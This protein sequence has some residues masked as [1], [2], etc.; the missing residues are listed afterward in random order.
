MKKEFEYN[1]E[2]FNKCLVGDIEFVVEPS[3]TWSDDSWY[4]DQENR[5]LF[6]ND[7]Y[8]I[9]QE[10]EATGTILGG[11]LCTFNLLQ[12]T[13]FMPD[14]NNS[15]LFLEDDAES[16]GSDVLNFDRNLQSLIHLPDFKE[17]KG[18]VFGRFQI[19]AETTLEKLKFIVKGKKELRDLPIIADVN[20][21]HTNPLMTFPIG[22]TASLIIKDNSVELKILKH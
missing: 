4:K 7:G 13:E 5:T 9:I 12:G 14:L 2:Y 11:N 10:G 22:G 1:L 8:K 20:F 15:I 21:G 18:L 16:P 6:E 17:V 19:D 3:K